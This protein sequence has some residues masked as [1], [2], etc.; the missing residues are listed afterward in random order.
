MTSTK[1]S[2]VSAEAALPFVDVV[3]EFD[4][5]AARV[6]RAHVDPDQFA[7]TPCSRRG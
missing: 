3:R 4:A 5:P 6:Y 2:T 1:T 7:V